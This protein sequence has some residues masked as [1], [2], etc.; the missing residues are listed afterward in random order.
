MVRADLLDRQRFKLSTETHDYSKIK[1][2]NHW[3]A[4]AKLWMC[5]SYWKK[6]E[7]VNMMLCSVL[8]ANLSFWVEW[9]KQQGRYYILILYVTFAWDVLPEDGDK[10]WP[11][12]VAVTCVYELV[13]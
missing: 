2:H 7:Y 4:S 6:S 10:R 9:K 3:F 8:R 13:R 11:K 5:R 12:R 1:F